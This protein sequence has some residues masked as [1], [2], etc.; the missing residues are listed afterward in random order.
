[1]VDGKPYGDEDNEASRKD[2]ELANKIEIHIHPDGKGNTP[3]IEASSAPITVH[4]NAGEVTTSNATVHVGRDVTGDVE[5]SNGAITVNGDVHGNAQTSNA[6][7][8]A[9][10]VAGKCKTSNGDIYTNG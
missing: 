3:D 2:L 7:I 4:G 10:A 8:R 1:M 9:K 6:N 5:T